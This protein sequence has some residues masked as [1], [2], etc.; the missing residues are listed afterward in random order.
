MFKS[1]LPENPT[2]LVLR[3]ISLVLPVSNKSPL[4]KLVGWI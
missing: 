2:P 3:I 1:K 4:N